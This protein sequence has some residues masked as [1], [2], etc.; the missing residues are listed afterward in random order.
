MTMTLQEIMDTCPDWEKFC[1]IH[2]YNEYAV[3]EGGGDI[4]VHLT[5]QQAHELGI[6]K[7][8]NE[9]KIKENVSTR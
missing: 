3:N 7:I 8:K 1:R 9:W 6:V 2:G 4:Q 5:I